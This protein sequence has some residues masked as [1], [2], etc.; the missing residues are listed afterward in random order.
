[1]NEIKPRT[2]TQFILIGIVVLYAGLLLVAPMVAIVQ[3]A[4]SKGLEPM[5][6]VFQDAEVINAFRL[7]F[8]LAFGAVVINTIAGIALAWILIRHKFVG[9]RVFDALVDAPF[10]FSPVVAGYVLI[11]LFGRGG[12][13]QSDSVKIAFAWPGML[14]ATIFVSLPFVT[15]EIQP[16]LAALTQ[17]QEHA[18]Y[19]LGASRLSTFR[20]IVIPQ[21][22]RGLLYGVVLT[23]ARAVGEFGAVAVSGGGIEGS[24]ETATLYIFRASLDRNTVGAYSVSVVLGLLAI[25]ILAVMNVLR[26]N[27]R[28]TEPAGGDDVHFA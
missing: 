4:F 28:G 2:P 13:F 14:L 7:T 15:R 26:R 27:E 12:W 10:A 3:G 9:K 20:R 16:V 19:T 18:A 11:V 5:L 22:W 24:T 8:G 25:A 21:I 17:E 23:F 1:M 6:K